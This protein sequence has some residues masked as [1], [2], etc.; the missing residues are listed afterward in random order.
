MVAAGSVDVLCGGIY[1]RSQAAYLARLRPQTMARWFDVSVGH[2]PAVRHNE[3]TLGSSVVGFTD[4]MQLM[5]VRSIR[6]AGENR[7]SLQKVR[8][9][10]IK[11][12]EVGFSSPL[13][14]EGVEIFLLGKDV[15]LKLPDGGLLMGSGKYAKHYVMEPVLR[16]YLEG[17]KYDKNGV[18]NIYR[19]PVAPGVCLDPT[20]Q[21][22]SP[23]IEKSSYT[24][25]TL[26]NAVQAEGSIKSAARIC[27][28]DENDVRMAL[29]F[30]DYLRGAA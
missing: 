9:I 8:E 21:W 19:P 25:A 11:A 28:V 27:N 29:Q 6:V 24:V 2:G 26:V 7:I 4:L 15:V 16:P 18:A 17:V 23:I 12:E 1:T 30:E 5:A 10:T 3:T 22:G 13:A 20:R 14:I